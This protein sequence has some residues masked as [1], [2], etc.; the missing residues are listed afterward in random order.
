MRPVLPRISSQAS[1]FFFCGIRLL[2][3]ENSSGSS[4]KPEFGRSEENHVFGE[5]RKM[6][7]ERRK[8]E[9]KFEREVAV[10]DGVQAVGR[11]A[12]K[13]QIA[14]QRFAI[15]RK[16]AARERARAERANIG[17]RR[18]GGQAFGVAMK[19][20]AVREQPVRKQKRLRV[21]HVRGA[22]HGNAADCF[23]PARRWRAAKRRE[24]A[25][26]ISR[27]ASLTYMRNSVA[28]ISLR[29]RPVCSFAP[30]GPS[31]SISAVSA[32]W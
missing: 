10:A 2:P 17:A 32:K 26:A 29:L 31:F 14:R 13:S 18:G 19:S 28:T 7:R 23:R 11:D 22:R 30:S 8:R 1:G 24:R 16:S 6:H 5:A 4:M 27:A 25:A 15:E 21:L 20:F 3:V 9:K 12:R